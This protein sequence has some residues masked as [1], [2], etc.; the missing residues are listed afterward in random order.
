MPADIFAD[1]LNALARPKRVLVSDLGL[2]AFRQLGDSEMITLEVWKD[3]AASHQDMLRIVLGRIDLLDEK[4]PVVRH[5]IKK[6]K[7]LL[8]PDVR[9]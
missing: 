2:F 7:P 4:E 9:A 6:W 5:F 8:Q 3:V 1:Q